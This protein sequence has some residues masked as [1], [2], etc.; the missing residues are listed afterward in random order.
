MSQCLYVAALVL[1]PSNKS[2]R[3]ETAH[4]VDDAG[5]VS[6]QFATD[7]DNSKD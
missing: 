6:N 7:L 2:L 1:R 4:R 5:N 3:S